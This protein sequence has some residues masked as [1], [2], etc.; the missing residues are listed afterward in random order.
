[1]YKGNCTKKEAEFLLSK[2][3]VFDIPH[4]YIL[5]KI[6][7]NPIL[8]RPIVAG[9]NWILTPASIFV[10]H[11]LKEFY[12]KFENILTDSLSLIKILEISKF[13]K[14]CFL[15]TIDFSSLYTNISV[16]DAMELIKR[17]F[18]RYQNVIPNA[19][20][21]SEL[22]EIVLKGAVMKF[23]EEFFMQIMGTVMGTNLAS[24]LAYIYVYIWQC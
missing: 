8:G 10:G 23:Q 21:I 20:L 1:M 12:S 15:F 18:F 17:L 6:L 4:F 24:I 13:D 14:D 19:H 7:K 2:M 5:W 11:Y 3:Y 22:M 16:K 9:Y